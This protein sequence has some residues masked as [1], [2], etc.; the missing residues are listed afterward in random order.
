MKRFLKQVSLLIGLIVLLLIVISCQHVSPMPTSSTPV[1]NAPQEEAGYVLFVREDCTRGGGNICAT[2]L[3]RM[4]IDETDLEQLTFD[5]APGIG[6]HASEN[7]P[8]LTI[9]SESP[10]S[11]TVVGVRRVEIPALCRES[12]YS[13]DGADRIFDFKFSPSGRYISFTVGEGMCGGAVLRILDQQ[14]RTCVDVSHDDRLLEWV[15]DER[16]IVAIAT[17]EGGPMFI[18]DLQTKEEKGIAGGGRIDGWNQAHTVAWG[19]VRNVAFGW[20]FESF[21]AYNVAADVDVHPKLPNSSNDSFVMEFFEGWGPDDTYLVYASRLISYTYGLTQSWVTTVTVG[22]R[23]IYTVDILG[24]TNKRLL[25]DSL[26]DYFV[27]GHDGEY[28]IVQRTLYE[29]YSLPA[30]YSSGFEWELLQ[31]CAFS[32]KMCPE[33]EYFL[34]DALSGQLLAST[35]SESA[36][37]VTLPSGPNLDSSPVYQ[38]SDGSFA[39][40]TGFDNTG[41]WRV[42]P[43][44]NSVIIADGHHFIY[45]GPE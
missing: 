1:L 18:Y 36:G 31:Q 16:A 23:E 3:W 24:Q 13:Y 5:E 7:T 2:N 35:T 14:T 45:I 25:G 15:S 19:K 8:A 29:P 38:A 39:L 43:P 17:C 28:L 34:V 4:R 44:G 32:G 27:R 37:A 10:M 11:D 42:S 26:H 22:P 12:P 41:L 30:G 21:W 9:A 33:S 40:Y 6:Y 20:W